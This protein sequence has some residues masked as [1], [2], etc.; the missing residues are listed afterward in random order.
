MSG[1]DLFAHLPHVPPPS[2][3]QGN[4]HGQVQVRHLWRAKC[5]DSAPSDSHREQAHRG[6]QIRLYGVHQNVQNGHGTANPHAGAYRGKALRV[7]VLQQDVQPEGSDGYSSETPHRGAPLQL[8]GLHETVQRR[9]NIQQAQKT[10]PGRTAEPTEATAGAGGCD[11]RVCP[12][13]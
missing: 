11:D 12:R 4:P 1:T 6:A 3:P 13:R 5:L 7:R 2:P 10:V 8:S 9:R